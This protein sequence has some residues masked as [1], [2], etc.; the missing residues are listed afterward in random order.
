MNMLLPDIRA[1]RHDDEKKQVTLDLHLPQTLAHFS[2]HFPGFPL[3]P[4]V[5]Q[6]DWAIRFAHEHLPITGKLTTMENIKFHALLLPD[7]ELQLTLDWDAKGRRLEF[8]YSR[9]QHKYSSGRF[10]FGG[11]P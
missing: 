4:G 6:I 2:G 10:V 7:T 11:R 9:Q 5:V 8:V 1:I 3:T